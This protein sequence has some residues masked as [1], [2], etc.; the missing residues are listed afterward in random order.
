MPPQKSSQASS[1]LGYCSAKSTKEQETWSW[2]A[3]QQK[4]V[5]AKSFLFSRLFAQHFFAT[6]DKFLA[7]FFKGLDLLTDSSKRSSGEGHEASRGQQQLADGKD[8]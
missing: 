7:H 4:I 2:M 1:E 6:G 3:T 8:A 5:A